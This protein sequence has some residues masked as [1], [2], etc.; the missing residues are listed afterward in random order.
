MDVPCTLGCRLNT[1]GWFV[2]SSSNTTQSSM[3]DS[4]GWN[5]PLRDKEELSGGNPL[6][7][8]NFLMCPHTC[9]T[10]VPKPREIHADVGQASVIVGNL[11]QD[12]QLAA[13][14]CHDIGGLEDNSVARTWRMETSIY[15]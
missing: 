3:E 11:V 4:I 10:N 14:S 5:K 15:Y 2:F 8:V 9:V 7:P 1:Y 12:N 6:H 13:A